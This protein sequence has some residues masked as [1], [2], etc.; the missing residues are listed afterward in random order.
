MSLK[1]VFADVVSTRVGALSH[2]KL[3]GAFGV[4]AEV[5]EREIK[6]NETYLSGA[7]M[8]C[9]VPGDWSWAALKS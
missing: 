4:E 8:V 3:A 2:Y 1:G 6:T 7:F 5:P 9:D